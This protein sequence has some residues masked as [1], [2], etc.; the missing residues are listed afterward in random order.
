M[1]IKTLRPHADGRRLG[2]YLTKDSKDNERI[3][4]RGTR[5]TVALDTRGA[6]T[7]MA[8]SR[9]GARCQQPLYHV[10]FNAAKGEH[11]T[12][13]QWDYALHLW[14]RE[15]DLT[16]QQRAIV[17]HHKNGRWHTHVVYNR[18][19]LATGKAVNIGRDHFAAKR[20]A[21]QIEQELGLQQV[22]NTRTGARRERQPPHKWETEQ[23]RRTKA[24]AN[25]VRDRIAEAWVLSDTG[26]TFQH[27]LAAQ[28]LTLA[29][30]NRRPFVVLD[31]DGNFFALSARLL[32]HAR[33]KD[34]RAKLG[35]LDHSRLPTV[36]TARQEHKKKEQEKRARTAP[37][38]NGKEAH[39]KE[40]S[41][42]QAATASHEKHRREHMELNQ[43]ARGIEDQH[44]RAGAKLAKAH[45]REQKELAEK[46]RDRWWHKLIRK[47]KKIRDR[48]ARARALLEKQQTRELAELEEHKQKDLAAIEAKRMQLRKA[49][50]DEASLAR[51]FQ[52]QTGRAERKASMPGI[53][54]TKQRFN[55]AANRK[56]AREDANRR[57]RQRDEF[58]NEQ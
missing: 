35:D 42:E 15:M 51:T 6:I 55:A 41:V 31:K 39:A 32:P 40:T 25:E 5:G 37:S 7:E 57:S 22:R 16:N 43:K 53:E 27:A 3:E 24:D 4:E 48:E 13:E 52:E 17:Q 11:L 33:M 19:N 14:E 29:Q 23:T 8:A 56:R 45:K 12:A 10:V 18:I 44:T 2:R 9:H 47:T 50:R 54:K 20:V 46:Q 30:G 36:T 28:G 38:T 26:R 1:I 58:E 34:I 49:E 21:R